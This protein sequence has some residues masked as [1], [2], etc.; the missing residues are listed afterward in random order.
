MYWQSAQHEIKNL[1]KESSGACKL[2][3]TVQIFIPLVAES[4]VTDEKAGVS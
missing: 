4:T 1:S 3:L 2:L